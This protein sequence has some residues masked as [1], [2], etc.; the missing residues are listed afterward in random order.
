MGEYR[1]AIQKGDSVDALAQRAQLLDGLFDEAEAALSSDSASSVST[2][3]GAAT[4]LLREGLEALLIVAAMIAFVRKAGRV[5]VMPYI[6]GGWIGALVAGFITWIVATSAM[7]ISGAS[8]ELMEGFGSVFAAVV[9]IFVGIWMHGKA[10]AGQWQRYIRER[11]AKALSG[12]SAWLL[13]GLVFVVVYRE[14]FETILF[15]AALWTQGD[16][17]AMLAGALTAVLALAAIAWALLRY[18]QKLPIAKFFSYSSWLMV[19]LAVVLAGKGMAAL[20]EAGVVGISVLSSVPRISMIGLFPTL[21]TIGAQLVTLAA[22]VLGFRWN[23]A[24]AAKHTLVH[25]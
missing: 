25:P 8:R 23:H 18:S 7:E 10:Q 9:L 6:H 19:I 17:A 2:F 24:K 16:G 12:R 5:E 21:Q 13:F 11:M 14:V 4:I 3:V 1:A 20:Q 22:L 15:Y